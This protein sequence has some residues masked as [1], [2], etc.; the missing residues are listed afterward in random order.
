MSAFLR[1]PG[2]RNI[3]H[4]PVRAPRGV[5]ETLGL[6][7]GRPLDSAT[8]SHMES[9]FGYHFGSVR[10]H[11][12][13]P[14]A[15]SASSMS[16][17]AYTVGRDVV[18]AAGRYNPR[19]SEGMLLLAHEL[20]H[21]VQQGRN[22]T[23]GKTTMSMAGQESEIEADRAAS[24]VTRGGLA[25]IVAGGPVPA[26]QRQEDLTLKPPD[27]KPAQLRAPSLLPP[28]QRLHLDLPGLGPDTGAASESRTKVLPSL[29]DITFSRSR[30][31]TLASAGLPPRLS[32]VPTTPAGAGT[33]PQPLS[34]VPPASKGAPP[35]TEPKGLL[36]MRGDTAESVGSD[37][38]VTLGKPPEMRLWVSMAVLADVARL[39]LGVP[40][41]LLHQPTAQVT[42]GMPLGGKHPSAYTAA[43]ISMTLLNLHLAQVHDR[44]LL[45][46]GLGQLA[47]GEKAGQAQA[48]AGV[49][50]KL[51]VTK[52]VAVVFSGAVTLTQG[53][54]GAV[55]ASPGP[56][57]VRLMWT[58]PGS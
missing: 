1:Q 15:E 16:S 57:Y 26:V 54:G 20:A 10:V 4:E 39:R 52:Q 23:L 48:Q 40:A 46:L 7:E 17:V 9:G 5:R 49:A 24:D 38:A 12:D 2:R 44:D 14:S 3:G 34:N 55:T 28:D 45:Q 56:F 42:V 30:L 53:T 35:S 41:D 51:N 13:S 43:Q 32:L 36:T 33:A 25:G 47:V 50:A 18:F 11:D 6:G 58:L 27:F 22:G 29:G 19:T 8:R 21:V 31:T 37:V